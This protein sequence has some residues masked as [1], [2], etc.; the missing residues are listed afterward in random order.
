MHRTRT[1]VPLPVERQGVHAV[2]L[3][4]CLAMSLRL[5]ARVRGGR[6]TLDEPVDLPDGTI[7]DLVP[8]NDEDDLDDADRER[9]HAAL[10]RSAAQFEAGQGIEAEEALA[11]LRGRA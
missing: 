5:R 6:L 10:D 7:V 2:D 1:C 3:V 11:R 4:H 9:L 8:A